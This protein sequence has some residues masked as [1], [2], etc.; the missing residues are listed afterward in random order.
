MSQSDYSAII[1]Q[2]QEQIVALTVQVGGSTGRVAVG[3][4]VTRPQTFDRTLSKVLEFIIA[5]KLYIKMKMKEVVVEEQIQWVLLYVQ[6]ES[7]DI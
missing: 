4:E 2:L 1:R 6:R 5:C 3:T 7:V